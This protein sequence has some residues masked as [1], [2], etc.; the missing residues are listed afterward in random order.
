MPHALKNVMD[1]TDERAKRF[2]I[3]FDSSYRNVV[4]RSFNSTHTHLRRA[5]MAADVASSRNH[6]ESNDNPHTNFFLHN[7]AKLHPFQQSLVTQNI[8]AVESKISELKDAKHKNRMEKRRK[9]R[10]LSEM[11]QQ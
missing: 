4:D 9:I 6:E 7:Q 10:E 3:S 5:E 1:L 8:Q 2:R 11:K